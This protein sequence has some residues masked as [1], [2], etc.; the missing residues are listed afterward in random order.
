[1]TGY[2]KTRCVIFDKIIYFNIYIFFVFAFLSGHACVQSGASETEALHEAYRQIH[3]R[4]SDVSLYQIAGAQSLSP[5]PLAR[6]S[7]QPS[8]TKESGQTPTSH[9]V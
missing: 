4:D 7:L 2:S 5:T 1:M 9:N 3:V 8:S 6:D